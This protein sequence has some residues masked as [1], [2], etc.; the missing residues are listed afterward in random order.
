[1][2]KMETTVLLAMK[3]TAP[4][5]YRQLESQGKLATFLA[6]YAAQIE[7]QIATLMVELANR[8]GKNQAATFQESVGIMNTACQQ[9]TEIVLSQMLEF[10]QEETSLSN[11]AETLYSVTPT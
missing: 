3:E 4:D 7:D 2:D 11:P 6:D 9:A 5:L 10:P 8:Q 1:M